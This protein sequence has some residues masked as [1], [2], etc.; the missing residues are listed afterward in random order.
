M[1][2]PRSIS[3]EKPGASEPAAEGNDT[4]PLTDPKNAAAGIGSR[5]L[6][7][8][9]R[10]GILFRHTSC[11]TT[12]LARTIMKDCACFSELPCPNILG[13]NLTWEWYP[14][15]DSS[16][17]LNAMEAEHTGCAAAEPRALVP[18]AG[19]KRPESPGNVYARASS[20]AVNH[21]S[22]PPT[23]EVSLEGGHTPRI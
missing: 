23:V 15:Y 7:R 12:H 4:E 18:R 6:P 19:T 17:A 20:I 14:E 8:P 1:R 22:R 21:A 5:R 13:R 10:T 16:L 11:R 2:L 3:P 9:Q